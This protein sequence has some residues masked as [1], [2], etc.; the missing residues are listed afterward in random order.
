MLGVPTSFAAHC[1]AAA[2]AD[3]PAILPAAFSSGWLQVAYDVVL[4]AVLLG[5]VSLIPLFLIWWERKVSAHIQSRIG[6]SRGRLV[7]LSPGA[8]FRLRAAV[9]RIGGDPLR[10]T[11]DL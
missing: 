5:A 10:P 1:S 3:M 7:A 4:V 2:L 9:R 8:L 11:D 6:P